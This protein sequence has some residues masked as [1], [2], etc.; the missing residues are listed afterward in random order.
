MVMGCH[1]ANINNDDSTKNLGGEIVV[2][3]TL[4]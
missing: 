4:A 2:S 3:T 1:L